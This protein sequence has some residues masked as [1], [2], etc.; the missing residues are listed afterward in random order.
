MALID[1][2]RQAFGGESDEATL[3]AASKQLGLQPEDIAHDVGYK[4]PG[5]WAA[6]GS[7]AIDSYQGNLWGIG[8]AMGS[9]YAGRRR[10]E[11]EAQAELARGFARSQGAIS[12]YKDVGGVR[13]ALDYA[14]GLAIDSAPYLAEALVGGVSGGSSLLA[15]GGLGL[16]SRAARAGA[17]A[18]VASYPSAVGDVLSAQR[19][20]GGKTDLLGA[21]ALGVPYAAL[22][23]VGLEGA[24]ARRQLYR[25]GIEALDNIPGVRGAAART[26]VTMGRAGLVEGATETG[27]ELINQAGRN[28]V[29]PDAG[30]FGDAAMDRYGESF[31]GGATLGGL[32]GGVGGGWRRSENYAPAAVEAPAPAQDLLDT[33]P[34]MGL[35]WN[36]RHQAG[37][38]QAPFVAFPDGS[39]ATN[40]DEALAHAYGMTPETLAGIRA[41]G[42]RVDPAM[43]SDDLSP[44]LPGKIVADEAGT[45]ALDAPGADALYGRDN[46]D[47]GTAVARERYLEQVRQAEERRQLAAEVARKAQENEAN[48]ARAQQVLGG[49][50]GDKAVEL[51]LALEQQRAAGEITDDDFTSDAALL[52]TN[53]FGK[54]KSN[55][56]ARA[57]AAKEKASAAN[58]AGDGRPGDDLAGRSDGGERTLQGAGVGVRPDAP[59]AAAQA[60]DGVATAGVGPGT[61]TAPADAL[62]QPARSDARVFNDV[63]P[64]PK[65]DLVFDSR[66]ALLDWA[67]PKITDD[68]KAQQAY[69]LVKDGT[70]NRAAARELGVSEGSIRQWVAAIDPIVERLALVHE[71]K[72]ARG[73]PAQAQRDESALVRGMIQARTGRSATVEQ[74][75]RVLSGLR[76]M[77]PEQRNATLAEMERELS[78]EVQTLEEETVGPTAQDVEDTDE[79]LNIDERSTS[80]AAVE[81]LDEETAAKYGRAVKAAGPAL[82]SAWNDEMAGYTPISHRLTWDQLNTEQRHDFMLGGAD[83]EAFKAVMRMAEKGSPAANE[84]MKTEARAKAAGVLAEA[85]PAQQRSMTADALTR[86]K[87][88]PDETKALERTY[89]AEVNT[90]VFLDK[91]AIDAR[92][93]ATNGMKSLDRRGVIV[94]KV[95]RQLL[96]GNSRPGGDASRAG[97]RMTLEEMV[98]LPGMKQGNQALHD[99]GI[100][101]ATDWVS[102]WAT[103]SGSYYEPKGSRQHVTIRPANPDGTGAGAARFDFVHEVGHAID[104]AGYGSVYSGHPDLAF[105]ADLSPVGEVARELAEGRQFFPGGVSNLL[106]YPFDPSE[107]PKFDWTP[108]LQSQELFAQMF[109]LYSH[110]TTRATLAAMS[111]KAVAFIEA[112]IHDVKAT[113]AYQTHNAATARRRAQAFATAYAGA[114]SDTG[115]Q[116][117]GAGLP[118]A[119][120]LASARQ[121]DIQAYLDGLNEQT[122]RVPARSRDAW[123]NAKDFFRKHAPR[124][125]TSNQLAEQF[126]DKIKTLKE[127][128]RIADLMRVESTSQQMAY[129]AVAKRWTELGENVRKKLDEVALRATLQE[130]HPDVPFTHELNAHLQP[131]QR[132]AHAALAAQYQALPAGAKS[133]YQDAKKAL[134]ESRER[135]VQVTDT[136]K[137]AYGL[138]RKAPAPIRG[139]YFPLM[140]FG[141]YLAIGE[142]EA[143][144]A[145]ADELAAAPAGATRTKLSQ[146]LDAMK[147][148]PAHYVVSAHESRAEMEAAVKRYA[149]QGLE[150]RASMAQ[151][152]VD[153]LP[154]DVHKLVNDFAAT[155]AS[156]FD[157]AMATEVLDAYKNLLLKSLPEMHALQRQA[158]RK[159]VEGASPDML[160]AF[161]AAGRQNAFYTARLMYSK[162]AAETMQEMKAEVKG[163]VDLMHVHR[164]MEQRAALNLQFHD[165]PVQDALGRIGHLWFLAA[166]PT[167]L[168]MNSLQPWLVSAPVLAGKFGLPNTTRHLARATREALL[169]LKDARFKDGKWSPWEGI[170]EDSIPGASVSEDRKALRELMKRGVVDEGLQ[171]EMAAF[172]EG[173]TGTLTTFM[174]GMGWFSQQVELVNRVATALAAFRLARESGMEYDAAVQEAYRVTVNTQMDYSQEN[175]ARVMRTGGGVPLAKLVFQFRRY[176]QAMLYLLGDNIKKLGSKGERKAAAATLAYLALG[177]GMSAGVLGLPFMGSALMAANL[178]RDDD[179]DD[180]DAQ[181]ALRN[182]LTDLTG[183]KAVA[184]VLAKGL[185]AMF[186]VDLSQRVGLGNVGQ[187]FPRLEMSGKTGKEN[188]GELAVNAAGPVIGGL[189]TQLL[190]AWSLFGQGDFAKGTERMLPKVAA[191]VLK[192]ARYATDGF[193]DRKGEEI[194]SSEEI[195]P[196]NVLLRAL[197]A[198]STQESDYY[199]GTQA[200]RGLQQALKDRKAVLGNRF[201]AA[202][203]TGDMAKVREQI[204]AYNADHPDAPIGAKEEISWRRE[205]QK[206][207]AQRGADGIKVTKRDES[208]TELLRFA[209]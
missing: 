115:L 95:G 54:V 190:D 18:A 153:A 152:R 73:A 30:Y 102:D 90:P 22:N 21:A 58:P 49:K 118:G 116:A 133:I 182:A 40:E 134:A 145:L 137:S 171:S 98:Q 37:Q 78:R 120:G 131:D 81:G 161:A 130:I 83:A 177:A 142:S 180:G 149:A 165:T 41:G 65:A 148:D 162:A 191:D 151:Q 16:A 68:E 209:R 42:P 164:E 199:E 74:V 178:L 39:V 104:M 109:A 141:D 6:R 197:G 100:P 110:P 8:E 159:G 88:T 124:F 72:V 112:V 77:A 27:Q 202:L 19:E 43:A 51:F 135:M 3:L 97:K 203:R 107:F 89:G 31:V 122:K 23:S 24:L 206:A 91:L 84:S 36:G 28:Q 76:A 166:S 136:L 173:R 113:H 194:L 56:E 155:M 189:G 10:R 20:E 86:A 64:D 126:G 128:V 66:P 108:T 186:G 33:R 67:L 92:R 12:S 14:G 38:G 123:T 53:K 105:D 96:S 132:A 9:D 183:D 63:Q 176:Q 69:R 13:D 168:F 158:E 111:P 198:S 127:A 82:V 75:N 170:H 185:P 196:W 101:H 125:L 167:Y 200:L 5:K 44:Y 121:A 80:G 11:N 143:Y 208:R 157:G 61:D 119:A 48:R 204:D 70:S 144:K 15:R 129:D 140:R 207:D 85:E 163:D 62:K 52:S 71:G 195:G 46:G 26:G 17:G 29:N 60:V 187:L 117:G 2:L 146:R 32:A 59:G 156:K 138:E 34:R 79:N 106:A 139:P 93:A 1:Q 4:I 147:R 99:M 55:I 192:A 174:R 7:A 45:A 87:L 169:V 35:G 179:D 57:I 94:A 150:A 114:Q 181:T 175:T 193:T 103:G 172:S 184:L 160:R 201:K 154:R 205:A 50:V 188:M 47:L 25:S